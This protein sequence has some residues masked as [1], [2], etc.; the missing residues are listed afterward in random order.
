MSADGYKS[1]TG[2][3]LGS[4]AEI[5]RGEKNKCI[6]SIFPPRLHTDSSIPRSPST[7]PPRISTDPRIRLI[8]RQQCASHASRSTS[9]STE[10][11]PTSTSPLQ[12]ATAVNIPPLH[13]HHHPHPHPPRHQ[14]FVTANI[15]DAIALPMS[16]KTLHLKF[17]ERSGAPYIETN[18]S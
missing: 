5:T 16:T 9:T 14:K 3:H 7:H 15:I 8:P 11:G 18:Q 2:I 10:T 1:V 6:I 12:P 4:S 13:H 17:S